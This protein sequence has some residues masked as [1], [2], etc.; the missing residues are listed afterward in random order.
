MKR[1]RI[2]GIGLIVSIAILCIGLASA[3]DKHF[4]MQ[5]RISEAAQSTTI[6]DANIGPWHLKFN[7]ELYDAKGTLSNKGTVEEWWADFRHS[8][9]QIEASNYKT[10]II[11]NEKG[12]FQTKGT[13]IVPFGIL[14]LEKMIVEPVDRFA[15]AA[16]YSS[17]K[18][19]EAS[20]LNCIEEGGTMRLEIPF[21]TYCFDPE[22]K[23]FLRE[24]HSKKPGNVAFS[25]IEE[26][27][28][29]PVARAITLETK[30]WR[31]KAEVTDLSAMPLSNDLF[32][33]TP[34][35]TI[36]SRRNDI[37]WMPKYEMPELEPTKE[38]YS[39]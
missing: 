13:N 24:I 23:G 20:S 33:R 8:K 3:E 17:N 14:D 34:D 31:G 4:D 16:Y 39:F 28:D 35:M 32:L 25:K 6:R 9:I 22:K 21:V 12:Y 11:Q 5:F 10:T 29:H 1:H 15:N 38:L 36:F 37:H 26:F 27:N 18:E 2:L 30:K 19:S 7:F